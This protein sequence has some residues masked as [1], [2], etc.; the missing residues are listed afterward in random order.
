MI[1]IEGKQLIG[2]TDHAE[3]AKTLRSTN[4]STGDKLQYTFSKATRDEVALACEKAGT[5]FQTYRKKTGIEKAYF[6]ETIAMEIEELGEQLIDI[7]SQETA[8]PK[9]RIESERN[10]TK[11]Q[12]LMFASMLREGSWLDARIETADPLRKPLPKPDMRYLHV[13]LGP[14]VV[15]GASNFPL[16]FSVAGGDTASA[17][18][19][20]CP[21]V[22]KAHSAHPATSEL[23]AKAILSAA[24]Q[25]QM[26]DGVFSL[27]H[28]DGNVVGMQLVKHSQ[29]KA[30]GLTGSF[31]A[32]KALFDAAAQREHPI[33]VY[34]EMGSTNPVFV[35]PGALRKNPEELA[36][37]FAASVTLGVGQFCTNPGMMLYR[38]DTSSEIFLQNLKA[39]FENTSGGAMLTDGIFNAYTTGIARHQAIDQIDVLAQG[40]RT[41]ENNSAHPML[42]KTTSHVLSDHPDLAEEIFGPTSILVEMQTKDEMLSAARNLSGH[43]TATIHG[44]EED[45][46]AHED[47]LDIL[48][49]K[50]GRI[51]IN[52]FPTGVEVCSAMVHGG[53][54]PATTDGRSTSVGTA[55]IFR[56]T[57]A[58]SFQNMPQQ[59]LPAEL[60]D[61]N[62]LAIWRLIN[63][64]RTKEAIK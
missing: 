45:L 11:N 46:L 29:I 14:V 63:G 32:G 54:F 58:V 8:L 33:P 47:L 62:P 44:T 57:R 38:K 49:Q 2:F 56:F 36:K 37:G 39:A 1:Q 18:A 31:A 13:G 7:C 10:R 52:G 53:P 41:G 30:V 20:G 50:V 21:V 5:A 19:A 12:L 60:K 59:M 51:I 27:L 43:L 34:A 35:L 61:E 55:S 9:T 25:T 22:F 48:T 42:F 15:F 6:L 17:L 24:K 26:P 40:K 23:V 16:A 3:G 4:A 64:V 28:G